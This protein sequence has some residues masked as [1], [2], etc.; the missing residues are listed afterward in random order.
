MQSAGAAIFV[1]QGIL[2]SSSM[3]MSLVFG[4]FHSFLSSNSKSNSSCWH[5]MPMS[6]G[7]MRNVQIRPVA[8][9]AQRF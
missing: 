9:L 5:G 8:N 3:C 1:I 2:S 4:S 6:S 7:G